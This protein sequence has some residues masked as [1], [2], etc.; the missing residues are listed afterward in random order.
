MQKSGAEEVNWQQCFEANR[1]GEIVNRPA[2]LG[3]NKSSRE[4]NPVSRWAFTDDVTET[5]INS[6][7]SVIKPKRVRLK[8]WFELKAIAWA[9][10]A[11]PVHVLAPSLPLL[12]MLLISTLNLLHD[13]HV[14]F[15]FLKSFL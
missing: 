4:A 15:Y 8:C 10:I 2:R 7:T 5:E 9:N 12:V 13:I 1:G 6:F 11:R 14:I 3:P